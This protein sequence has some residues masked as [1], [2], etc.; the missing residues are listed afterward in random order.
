MIQKFRT[1]ISGGSVLHLV[2]TFLMVLTLNACD[3]K[4]EEV[5]SQVPAAIIETKAL[6]SASP[7]PND[8]YP[9]TTP[10]I[11][12][13]SPQAAG[14]EQPSQTVN[15]YTATIESYYIDALHVVFQVRLT[16]G[17]ES[18]GLENLY[19]GNGSFPNNN[20]YDEY[21]K[22]IIASIGSGPAASDPA[23]IQF[24]YVPLTPL[25]GGHLKGQFDFSYSSLPSGQKSADFSFHFDLPIYPGLIF[26]PK[27]TVT[28][29]GMEILLD[30][31]TVT[32]GFT[33]IYLCYRNPSFAD[34]EIGSESVL[35]VDGQ[36]TTPYSFDV[37]YDSAIGGDRTGGS[38]PGWT[39]PIK[40]GR[41]VKY[42]FTIGSTDPK[43]LTLTIPQLEKSVADILATDQLA[44]AYPGVNARQAY[45]QFI[46]EHG[47][48]YKGPWE[49]SV[50]FKT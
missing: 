18:I 5:A 21:G 37:L 17:G 49:F 47:D 34:W 3:T 13:G 38:E 32:P 22:T 46:V 16:K 42:R 45:H 36:Q 8:P 24:G 11:P 4:P 26:N 27:Q 20:L 7:T 31:V 14:I 10:P 35:Q 50:S 43:S 6:P 41:C 15:G 44:T 40:A 2:A 30:R 12:L 9:S 48:V 1:N 25:T 28:A 39:P 23:L 19:G 29:N 33:Q